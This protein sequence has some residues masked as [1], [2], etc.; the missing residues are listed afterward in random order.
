MVYSSAGCTVIFGGAEAF[1]QLMQ[2]SIVDRSRYRERQPTR[3]YPPIRD[4]GRVADATIGRQRAIE[5][6][7]RREQLRA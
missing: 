2:D 5:R 3:E 1:T 4:V 7:L 6:S